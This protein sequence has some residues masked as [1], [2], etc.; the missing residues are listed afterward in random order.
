MSSQ[1]EAYQYTHLHLMFCVRL[2]E[3]A[4]ATVATVAFGRVHHVRADGGSAR[5]SNAIVLSMA[6]TRVVFQLQP[7]RMG[8]EHCASV[9]GAV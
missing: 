3:S 8:R 7:C 6:V 5:D 2:C 4:V 1:R 9:D